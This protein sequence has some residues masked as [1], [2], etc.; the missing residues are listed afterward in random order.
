M[1]KKLAIRS[2]YEKEIEKFHEISY[3]VEPITDFKYKN[4]I[5][6]AGFHFDNLNEENNCKLSPSPMSIE[7]S[8]REEVPASVLS[9]C[10]RHYW[11][12]QNSLGFVSVVKIPFK[13]VA[14]FAICISGYVDDGWDNGCSLIEIY[15]DEGKLVGSASVP[16]PENPDYSWRWMDRPLRSDDYYSCSALPWSEEEAEEIEIE[17]RRR[18]LY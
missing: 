6:G 7:I 12:L 14:T 5:G 3:C 15:D 18:N 1:D 16:H 13:E 17:K 10:D 11:Y 9:A 2:F 8:K 4:H